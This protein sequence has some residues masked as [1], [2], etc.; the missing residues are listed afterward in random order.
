[1]Y[2][3]PRELLSS[4]PGLELREMEASRENALCCGGGGDVEVS[5][6]SVSREVAGRRMAQVKATGARSVASACQQC[7]R[8]LEEGARRHKI[9]VRAVDVVEL[10]WRSMG[11]AES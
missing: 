11:A 3:A 9:R 8:T 10:I 2:D 6:P 7:R 5:D 4:I 1:V